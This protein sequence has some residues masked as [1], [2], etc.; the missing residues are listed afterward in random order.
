M[1]FFV[2]GGAAFLLAIALIVSWRKY[3]QAE[4]MGQTLT[5]ENENLRVQAGE[6]K[7]WQDKAEAAFEEKTQLREKLIAESEKTAEKLALLKEA[8][9]QFQQAFQALSAQAL[10]KNNEDFLKLAESRLTNAQQKAEGV[11]AKTHQHL[12]QVLTPLQET[13]TKVQTHV[14]SV[15][16]TRLSA[17][18]GL[19]AQVKELAQGQVALREETANLVKALR[20]PVVRGRWG[21]MQLRRVVEMSGMSPHC[22]F[23][24]QTSLKGEDSLARPDM[25]IRLPG[26]KQIVVDAKVP[27]EGYLAALEAKDDQVRESRLQD[28]ARQVRAHIQNLS[29]KGYW[30]ELQKVAHSPE[31][32]V[33]FLPGE[34]F[35]TAALEKAPTLIEEGVQKKVIVATPATLI[36]LLHAVAYGWR[37]E[38]LAENAREIASL[39]QDL[40]KRFGDFSNHLSKVGS[41]LTSATNSYNKAVGSFERR[42]LPGARKF[43]ELGD[44]ATK[45][46]TKTPQAIEASPRE[47]IPD[48][49]AS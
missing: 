13:L 40:Y 44:Y 28:H 16:K 26:G 38:Q 45:A 8:Q 29:S 24:E 14:E 48:E 2:L 43:K 35:F 17:Y 46:E 21:E 37:Q 25:I 4:I 15:E 5:L 6:K 18:A 47:M 36:A 22:D 9:D 20:A 27:L 49:I 34:T 30:L 39:G 33:L 32:V 31:F 19:Q 41:D 7:Y 3:R 42:I 10:S 11:F 23:V 1:I 12:S